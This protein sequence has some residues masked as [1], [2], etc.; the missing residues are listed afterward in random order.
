MTLIISNNVDETT[1]PQILVQKKL[2]IPFGSTALN[3]L[4]HGSKLHR[5]FRHE[6]QSSSWG[7]YI[8]RICDLEQDHENKAYWMFH[9]N[10]KLANKGAGKSVVKHGDIV[11]FRYTLY[12]PHSL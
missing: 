3:A 5:C 6:T 11:E 7:E 10:G 12:K 8:T 9:V 4:Q 2:T 1:P